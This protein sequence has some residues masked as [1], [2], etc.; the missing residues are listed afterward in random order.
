MAPDPWPRRPERRRLM[1]VGRLRTLPS[2]GHQECAMRRTFLL[3]LFPGLA[4]GLGLPARAQLPAKPGDWPGWRG[5]DRTG[6]SPETG[7]LK[8]WPKDG[9]KLLWKATGLG[10]GYSTPSVAGDRIFVLG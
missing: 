6:V 8:T 7:L 2:P 1:G 5:A 9:P 10:D 4:F 3:V